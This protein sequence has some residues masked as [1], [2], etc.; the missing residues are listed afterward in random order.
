MEDEI[1]GE[2]LPR[3]EPQEQITPPSLSCPEARELGFSSL[4]SQSLAT[5]CPGKGGRD[6]GGEGLREPKQGP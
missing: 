5:G 6:S 1:F 3:P 2:S 4:T